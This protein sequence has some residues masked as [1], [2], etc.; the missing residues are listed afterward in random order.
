MVWRKPDLPEE[1]AFSGDSYVLVEIRQVKLERLES[2]GVHSP[3]LAA[4]FGNP[5]PRS[6]LRGRLLKFG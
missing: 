4:F 2:L 6:L 3:Q 5:I 1:P